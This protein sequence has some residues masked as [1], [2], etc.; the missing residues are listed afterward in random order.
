MNPLP[1]YDLHGVGVSPGRSSREARR[2]PQRRSTQSGPAQNPSP[3]HPGIAPMPTDAGNR[4]T[5]SDPL[6]TCDA[7]VTTAPTRHI[8]FIEVLGQGGFGAVYLADVHRSDGF[9]Q[10]LAVKVLSPEMTAQP[11]LAARQRDEARLLAR[12]NHDSIVRVVDLTEVEGRP[13]VLMEYVAGVDAAC[14][15]HADVLSARAVMQVVAATAGALEA[16]WSSPDP[17]TGRPLRVVHRDIKPANLLVSRHGGVKVLDFGVARAEFDREGVTGSAQFGTARYMAP[18]QWLTGEAGHGVDIYALGVTLAELLG[19][20]MTR[21]PLLEA[22]FDENVEAALATVIEATWPSEIQSQVSSLLRDMLTFH[23]QQRTDAPDVRDRALALVDAMHGESLERMAPRVVPALMD[24]RQGRYKGR[25][26][27]GTV[28]IA[29]DTLAMDPAQPPAGPTQPGAPVP[30]P[31]GP[32]HAAPP[33]AGGAP[34]LPPHLRD[35]SAARPALSTQPARGLDD[36]GM[37]IAMATPTVGASRPSASGPKTGRRAAT[38]AAGAAALLLCATF[39]G[40]AILQ[41]DSPPDPASAQATADEASTTAPATP[42]AN[43]AQGSPRSAAAAADPDAKTASSS[44]EPS[45]PTAAKESN[46]PRSAASRAASPRSTPAGSTEAAP[47]SDAK[48][49]PQPA[50]GAQ[51]DTPTTTSTAPET[52][53]PVTAAPVTA[54]KPTPAGPTAVAPL[55][56]APL[57]VRISS[58]PTGARVTVDGTYQGTAPL[59]G[60]LLT[61]GAHTVHLELGGASAEHTLRVHPLRGNAAVWNAASNRFTIE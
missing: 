55:G 3:R 27:P 12:L 28:S 13:A 42:S 49:S 4:P 36:S 14:L 58:V 24:E 32:S 45:A 31:A 19:A 52:A 53:A 39:A 60:L 26:L 11:D 22:R 37:T 5:P 34:P 61:P 43:D 59:V 15:R 30:S 51:A 41:S 18:E 7:A 21:A 10:R 16:A 47:S 48:R 56:P 33:Q 57:P 25:P 20:T 38:W 29:P 9:V 6:G 1:Q 46:R 35:A 23:P 40:R 50:K 54:A 8:R 2:Q 44:K 17:M